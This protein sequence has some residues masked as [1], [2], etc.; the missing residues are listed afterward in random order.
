MVCL[1]ILTSNQQSDSVSAGA[2]EQLGNTPAKPCFVSI[3]RFERKKNLGLA[4]EALH[5]LCDWSNTEA[6]VKAVGLCVTITPE[7]R[8][9]IAN[10]KLVIAGINYVIKSLL[11]LLFD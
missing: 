11:K 2:L 5:Q 7:L 6:S 1:I 4:I 8:R 3:N 10:T 9:I